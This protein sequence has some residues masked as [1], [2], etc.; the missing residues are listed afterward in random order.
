[1]SEPEPTYRI[2]WKGAAEFLAQKEMMGIVDAHDREVARAVA[3]ER[4]TCIADATA[5]D[6]GGNVAVRI[7]RRIRARAQAPQPQQEGR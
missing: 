5:E 1:M 7:I 2:T 4:E 6:D 3:E